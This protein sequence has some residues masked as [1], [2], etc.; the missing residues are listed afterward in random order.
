MTNWTYDRT[1]SDP[2]TIT[3]TYTGESGISAS[4]NLTSVDTSETETAYTRLSFTDDLGVVN[5]TDV[6]VLKLEVKRTTQ[7][8]VN[9]ALVASRLA[10]GLGLPGGDAI[11]EI[12]TS[13]ECDTST[14]G[15]VLAKERIETKITT[16]ELA[17]GLAVPSY[18]D[19]T[20]G[21]DLFLS[22]VRD[23]QHNTA[24]NI[25]GSAATQTITKTWIAY[26]L[27]QDGQQSFAEQMRQAI[28]NGLDPEA[29]GE[30]ISSAVE[31][32]KTLV[33]QGTEVQVNAGR[34]P[35]PTKPDDQSITRD[36]LLEGDTG[37]KTL[38]GRLSYTDD[39]VDSIITSIRNYVMPFSPDDFYSWDES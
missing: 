16:S 9:G 38:T 34:V 1:I 22:T 25:D 37:E 36:L 14:L 11:T 19:Y 15:P 29:S 28:N 4:V 24:F 2:R 10:L 6:A 33:F 32:M 5:F 23:I 26:G 3:I 30:F 18:Q 7:A 17:G 27:T 31:S 21:V 13:Y 12:N 20:P 8:S 35:P 39:V